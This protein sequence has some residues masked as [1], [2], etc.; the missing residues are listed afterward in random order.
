M[1]YVFI[2]EPHVTVNKLYFLLWE[3]TMRYVC[4]VEPH[5]TVNKLYFLHWESNNALCV[6]C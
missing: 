4:I 2:V 1:R 6:Y 3:V 5:F